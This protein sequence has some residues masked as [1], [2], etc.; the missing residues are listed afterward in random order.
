MYALYKVEVVIKADIESDTPLAKVIKD[1]EKLPSGR[2]DFIEDENYLT[3]TEKFILPS[4]DEATM[5]VFSDTG[6]LLYTNKIGH[7]S[8]N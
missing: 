8:S 4:G 2:V 3:S 7:G 5:E 1:I 6:E